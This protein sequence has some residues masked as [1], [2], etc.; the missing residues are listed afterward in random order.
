MRTVT[1]TDGTPVPAL[2]LGTWMMG[3][4][5][6]DRRAEVEALR[7]GLDAG[8]TLVDTAEMYGDG[9]SEELVGE[10]IGGRRGEVFL[11]SK[12]LPSNASRDGVQ[13]ACERT[14]KRLGTDCLD[15]YLLHWR[16]GVPLAE[17]VAGFEALLAAGKIRRWGVSNF[18]VADLEELAGVTDLKACAANQVL[19]NP[20]HRG[21][22]FDLIPWQARHGLP[23]MAYSPIGQ[24]GALLRSPAL[25]AVAKRHDATPA[26]VALA[27]ALRHPHL[28]A[29]PK[30]GNAAR[31]R[32]NAAAAAL[33]LGAE[34]WAEI[35]AAYPPP[36]RKRDLAMI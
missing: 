25:A 28:F 1:L 10:A 18:D 21:I 26:Q 20:E 4:R 30:T 31:A 19:Y 16:G 34:D 36:R 23:V 13:R 14:L 6:A 15:L 2:G 33:T 8:M 17:T 24:G 7:A 22:E 9:R 3:D 32:E 5:P 27:W 11:V 29:I 35:D 12:V